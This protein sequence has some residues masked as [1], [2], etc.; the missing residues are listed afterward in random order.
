MTREE[1][2]YKKQK[3]RECFVKKLEKLDVDGTVSLAEV[4]ELKTYGALWHYAQELLEETGA[5]QTQQQHGTAT[6]QP[7]SGLKMIK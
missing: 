2:E 7:G 5:A 6:A 1:L 4:K 3:L